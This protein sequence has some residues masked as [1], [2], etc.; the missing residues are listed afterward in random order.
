MITD[1]GILLCYSY[2]SPWSSNSPSAVLIDN[3]EKFNDL[4]LNTKSFSS[5]W[6]YIEKKKL[7][8]DP[9]HKNV[10]IYIIAKHKHTLEK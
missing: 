7:V 1:I 10:Q 8:F 9:H 6:F 4:L 5:F 2:L 3:V